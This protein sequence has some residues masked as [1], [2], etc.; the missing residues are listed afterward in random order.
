MLPCPL[1]SVAVASTNRT[2][3]PV[4]VTASP[5]ATPGT[6]VRAATSLSNLALP[7][8]SRT[9]SGVI[10]TGGISAPVAILVATL[11]V[12]LP[13][14][15]SRLRTPASRVWSVITFMI[16]A[17]STVTSSGLSPACLTCRLSRWSRAIAT[18]SSSV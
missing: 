18:F 8:N 6:A 5:V 12:I 2:S 15:R 4:P 17:S 7:R 16:D 9:R 1:L 14:S 13:S 3:P 10:A 11:R